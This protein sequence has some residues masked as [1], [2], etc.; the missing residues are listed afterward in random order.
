MDDGMLSPATMLDAP[1]ETAMDLDYMDGLFLDG[2]W[3]ETADGTEFLHTSPSS[4]GVNLDPLIGWPATDMNG[5]FNM[6]QISRSN[7]EEGRKISTDEMSLGRKRIDMGQEE[8]SDQS[9]NNGFEGSE[10]CR[11]LWIGPGEHLG[12]PTSV[13]ERLIRAV[14]YIKDFVRDKDVLVQV[15]VPINRGGR[16][17]LI[18]ND[19]PFSQNS[20]CTRLTKYRDVSVTYEFTANEDSKKALGL[21]GRVFSRK[22]PEWTPD[23]RFF[24]SDEYPRVNH[25]HEHDVRGTVALPIF[26]QGSKNCLGVIEVVMVTQQVKYGSELEN[27]CKALEAVKLRSSDV[28]GHPNKKVFNRSNEAVLLEIQNTLKTACETH[29]L[30]LAQTW[31]SC[32]QQ[33][34]GGCRH[35]DEN[36]SC[37]VSTVDR[38]CF[39]ADQ[40]I[41]EFHEACSEHHLLKGEGIVGMAFKSNEPCFSSDITSFCNTEYPL[42]HHAKLFG[43][44]AAV[45]IRLRCIYISKTDFVLEFFLPVNCRDPEEQRVLLTSL[46]TIIQRSCRSLRL[47]TDKECREEN[48]QQSCRSLH[49]VT[50]VKLGE[51]SQFPFGE[52]GLG[53]NGRSAMQDMS[54]GGKPSE[55]LSSSG[56]QHRG[57]NYDLNGVVEDSGE[58]TTVGNGTLP[59]VGLGKTG[60][61]RRTKVDKTITLQVL[62]QYFAGS[63]KDA[64][65]SIG[66]CPTTLKRICRQHGIKRWPSRKI[67]KVGHSLQKLQLVIDSVEG[68]SGA[69]QIGSLYSNFQELA[70]P[71]LSGSGSG[72]PFGAKMG[73][74]LKTSN[75]V[76][77]SNLQRAAS[78]SPSSS[79]SQSSS[80]S[81]CFSSRSHQNIPHWNEA[82]SEDQMGGVNPCDGEL[83]RVKSEVEIHVSIMEGS[84]VPRRSQSCKS[85]CKHPGAECVVHTAKE[86]NGMAEAVEVQRVKVS[87]GEEKIRFRVHNRW[88][89][90]ELLNEIAKRFSISDISKFDLK[91][92]DDESEWVLLTSDTD[93]QECFHVYKSSR[94][95]TIKLSLQVSRRHKR[96]FLA[97]SGFS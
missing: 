13:M 4:F 50:D 34:R 80:S 44:H 86:S 31:A 64:A 67:K 84:N 83:K 68:A 33:S 77:M 21:P 70:S 15:W 9:E 51:E 69:F 59:D 41:Q 30:P 45:A 1:A 12:S 29:G 94:V 17:V 61:K 46:S 93:L 7:Q 38:A 75:E 90:E 57:F 16:N 63:L 73:D 91:Y 53:A 19:L 78:K 79:C 26:E 42:S 66:V 81:Q 37:C 89:H 8:C 85:L 24:R 18:T 96:N 52:A 36:Y 27:V 20:S 10:M 56:Y 58:C 6:T 2:C 40:R 97:S 48:M 39:V 23:V 43:L 28:I 82:G 25:A 35:S 92:L 74:C 54:K 14:G 47:V 72:P 62:R 60:E 11:R 65:K 95:Q 22:V 87:F 5:D 49:L 55:V 76:G 3:L 88:R 71:N 32:I